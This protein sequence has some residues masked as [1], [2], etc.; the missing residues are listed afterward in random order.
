MT[1]FLLR[2]AA[3]AFPL[4]ATFGAAAADL[5]VSAAASL[6]NAFQE[7]KPLYEAAH[8]DTRVLLNFGASGAL[9]QQMARGAPVDVFASADQDT[10]DQAQKQALVDPSTRRNFASNTLVVIV[11]R[12]ASAV[13]ASL[14]DLT[15]PGYKRIAIGLPASVPVGRY[16]K[17]VLEQ[18]GLWQG[19]EPRTIGAQ[20]VRQAL[21][22]AAR[23]EVDAAFVYATDATL[24]P[25][26][27]RVAF[28]VQSPMPVRYPIALSSTS[29]QRDGAR[30][31]ISFIQS[32]TAQAVLARFGFGKP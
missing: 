2:I 25:D 32:P 17:A 29:Q 1:R 9:L 16:T 5:T 14:A 23:G 4:L 28:S 11:P 18:A 30:R 19:I 6:T 27:V 24:M 31:F 13:P 26:R 15:Q 8:P 22:Y 7:L 10:M 3:L 12:G 21:D 20:N